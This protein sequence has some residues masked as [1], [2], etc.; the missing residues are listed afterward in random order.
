V[1][2]GCGDTVVSRLAREF[3]V[4]PAIEHMVTVV[5]AK[6]EAAL[7]ERC[8][9]S[10]QCAQHHVDPTV[11]T[12]IVVVADACVDDTASIARN[13]LGANG[14][15]I[16]TPLGCV[17]QARRLGVAAALDG[18]GVAPD[19]IWICSTDADT[20]VPSDW[21]A[22]QL[23]LARRSAHA[24]AGIVDLDGAADPVLRNDFTSSYLVDADGTHPHVHAANL[25]VR[26]DVY[27]AAGGWRAHS[28]GEEHDLWRRVRMLTEPLATDELCVVTASRL[29]GRAPHGFA[30]D[31]AALAVHRVSAA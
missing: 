3:T 7:I 10:L 26:A 29:T 13:V 1:T 16:E 9:R 11:T 6:D 8:V 20:V 4:H 14:T 5:P 27:L 22:V 18:A 24:I 17:G 23:A 31:L 15:V 19:R 30:A 2:S 28:T 25:G 21:L 12:S